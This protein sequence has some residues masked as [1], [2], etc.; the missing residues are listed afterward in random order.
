[1]SI[2]INTNIASLQAQGYLNQTSDRLTKTISR[3]TSGLRIVNSGDDAAGL[4]VANG[5]RSDQ[6][7]LTQG[8]RNANDGLSQLQIIDG[9]INNISQLLDRARTL[10]T[11]SASG[12]FTGDRAVLNSEFQS[13][14][15]EI[16]R[17]AQ[18]I[19]LDAN[20]AFTKSLSIFLGGGKSN[21]GTSVI[22]NGSVSLDLSQSAV[23][24]RALGLSG[25]Q[26]S[27]IAATDIGTGSASTSVSQIL[28]NA[29]NTGS[30]QTGGFTTFYFSGPGFSDSS[31]VGVS[32]NTAGVVD[33]GTLATAVNSAIAASGVGGSQAATAFKNLA[34]TAAINTDSTG[35]QQLTFASS[36]GGFQVQAG[37]RVSNALLGN[38]SSGSTGK[39]LTNTVTGASV[40]TA[41]TTTSNVLI[42]IQGSGLAAPVDLQI[43]TGTTTVNALTTLSSL[44]ANNAALQAAGITLSGATAVGSTLVFTSKR[45]ESFNVSTA[46]DTLNQFG[47]GTYNNAT[48][49][50]TAFDYTSITGAAGTFAA[51]AQTLE[52]SIGGGAGTSVAVTPTAATIAGAISALNTTFATTA[53]FSAA[54]LQASNSAGQIQI[55]STNG[56]AF[57]INAL[58][59]ANVFGFGSGGAAGSATI[60]G[61][62]TDTTNVV[63]YDS[64]G[65]SATA[66]VGFTPLVNG[67]D[68][69]TLSFAARDASGAEHNLSVVLQNNG[70]ARNARSLD[71]ALRTI[72]AQLQQSNDSTLNKIVAVKE[73]GTTGGNAEGIKF[74]STLGSFNVGVSTT[75]TGGAAGVGIP[76]SNF[77]AA[78]G[79]I[80]NSAVSAGGSTQDV[81]TQATAQNAVSSLANAV[82]LLGKSQAVVGK[83][84][85]QFNFAINLAQS[86]LTNLGASES[87]IRDADLAAESANLTKGQIGLQAAV[88]ALAQANTIPQQVLALI[89][90]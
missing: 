56:T 43:N 61:V 19:G 83:G 78:Q 47:L 21:N 37:D 29:T 38:F 48:S 18:S 64:G 76:N 81:S 39:D 31:K 65:A 7:V 77:A 71:E 69:Q 57:R 28:A 88:A 59:G 35:K 74:L 2:S 45:G 42:R 62:A 34:V 54:G 66:T 17:Q 49:G 46:G 44:V 70:T 36:V 63:H 33:A 5:Q 15:I 3:V 90:A 87:R 82:A 73:Y 67:Q 72:N 52:F 20:G 12:T 50:G 86:Q 26:A 16:T 84:Q 40:T 23:D 80:L 22:T 1:M 55:T 68:V 10:A 41:N 25:V 32:V 11:Q 27:G 24:A 51:A 14:V 53:S 4:A 85:N 8:I 9:G 60:T 79:T 89:K 75:G 6:A 58:G 30:E 13:D